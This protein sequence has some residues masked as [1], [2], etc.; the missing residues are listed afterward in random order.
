MRRRL[1]VDATQELPIT[2]EVARP[3]LA[4]RQAALAA[5]SVEREIGMKADMAGEVGQA[6]FHKPE[7]QLVAGEV[8]DHDDC[9]ARN[10]HPTHFGGKP[11]RV[12]YDR[13]NIEG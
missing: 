2:E 12:R 9:S 8:I 11:R 5:E 4:D 6:F 13:G 10:A 1:F 7:R 3:H